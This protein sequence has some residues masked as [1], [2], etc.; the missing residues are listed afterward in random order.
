MGK[1]FESEKVLNYSKIVEKTQKLE[2]FKI[3]ENGGKNSEA[4]KYGGINS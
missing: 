3:Y 4:Q 2:K 1:I